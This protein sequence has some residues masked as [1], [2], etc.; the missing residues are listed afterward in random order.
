MNSLDKNNISDIMLERYLLKE[1]PSKK[2]KELKEA[3][4]N[5]KSLQTR[6][7]ELENSNKEI[8]E[9]YPAKLMTDEIIKKQPQITF[10]VKG[11]GFRVRRLAYTAIPLL[12]LFAFA[13]KFYFVQENI[14]HQ[15]TSELGIRI[16]GLEPK[17]IIYKK[18]ET[19]FSKLA[20][21]TLALEGES[22]QLSYIA[23]SYKYG[24]IFSIDSRNNISLHFP[25]AY[26]HSTKLDSKGEVL[27]ESSFEL[28]DAPSFEKFYF[29]T[30]NEEIDLRW[31]FQKLASSIS[32]S[33]DGSLNIDL[34]TT[35][36]IFSQTL[37]K[38]EKI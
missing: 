25:S 29:V 7:Q 30:S 38:G 28:D 16:K 31:L 37:R 19:G 18:T 2:M 21:D 22:I 13:F 27:L 3:I 34:P 15:N 12:I 24:V 11:Y 26:S 20:K 17:L 23:A 9:K 6:L 8:F 33:K 5:D 32:S 35:M 4:A 36:K 1:L 10:R 14:E